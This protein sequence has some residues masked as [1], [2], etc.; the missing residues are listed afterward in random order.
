MYRMCSVHDS[1]LYH[2]CT[3]VSMGSPHMDSSEFCSRVLTWD[4]LCHKLTGTDAGSDV[5]RVL[6]GWG[7]V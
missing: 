1:Y 6:V 7:T 2:L 5:T 4:P 3:R